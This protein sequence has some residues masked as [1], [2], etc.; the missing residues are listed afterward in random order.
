MK[1]QNMLDVYK[2]KQKHKVNFDPVDISSNDRKS[3]PFSFMN[4]VPKTAN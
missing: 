3:V 1:T 4:S 2:K